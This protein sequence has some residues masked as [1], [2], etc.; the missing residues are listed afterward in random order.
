MLA[1]ILSY[2]AAWQAAFNGDPRVT[3]THWPQL[4]H[5]GIAADAD[6]PLA[7]YQQPGQVSP[8]LIDAVAAWI[9]ER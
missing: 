4:G 7:T 8:A 6:D 5:L 9:R 2:R 1:G 3:L